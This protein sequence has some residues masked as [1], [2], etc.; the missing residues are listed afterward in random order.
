MQGCRSKGF[1]QERRPASVEDR[2]GNGGGRE[3]GGRHTDSTRARPPRQKRHRDVDPRASAM[4]S[5]VEERPPGQKRH[6]DVDPRASAMPSPVEERPPGQKRHRDVDPRASAMPSPVEE[7]PPGQKWHRDVDPRASAMPSR[8]TG[9]A[10]ERRPAVGG[11]LE[12]PTERNP[13]AT[14]TGR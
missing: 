11:Q 9:F 13:W 14:S 2:Q 3:G 5:S 7:R 4:P 1:A 8:S 6:R 10:Q 12:P